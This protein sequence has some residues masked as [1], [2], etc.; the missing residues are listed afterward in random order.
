MK[1][2]SALLS[3]CLFFI[4][5]TAIQLNAQELKFPKLDV[6]PLDAA[7]YPRTAAFNNYME[8][9]DKLDSQIKVVYSRPKKKIVL[10]L[11]S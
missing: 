3:L 7:T 6:S 10:F 1:F 4:G 5:I 11:E 2:K 8:G 9:D